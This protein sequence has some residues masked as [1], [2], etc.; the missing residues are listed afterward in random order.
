V[1]GDLVNLS[2]ADEYSRARAWLERL[3]TPA[4]VTV[5]P[6]NH[7]VYV[8][9]A[10]PCPDAY[11]GDYMRGDIEAS[12]NQFPFLRRRGGVALI[13]MSSAVPSGPFL[14]IG[15]AGDRQFALL[16]NMLQETAGLFRIVLIHHPPLSPPRRYLRRLTDAAG[17]RRVLAEK[18]A[19][20][21]LHGHD[22]RRA[23]VWLEGPRGTKI[24][25]VGVPSASAS[26][27]HGSE[28]SAGYNLFRIDRQAPG[29]RCELICRHLAGDG[30][31]QQDAPQRLQ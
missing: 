24:P 5:I 7:D 29:S 31:M 10:R 16:A 12:P 3:G 20:L 15:K 17:L 9:A 4:N 2:L 30:T 25:A 27:P 18:G 8:R 28:D 6:G 26:A 13:A 23:L 21:L 19:E 22:H 1:T 11:W 14:A